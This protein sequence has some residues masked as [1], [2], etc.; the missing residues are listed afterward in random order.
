[1]L[2]SEAEA[3]GPSGRRLALLQGEVPSRHVAL[4]NTTC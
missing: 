2:A 3:P 1:M 4:S